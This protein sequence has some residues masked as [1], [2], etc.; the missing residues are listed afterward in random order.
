M[1]KGVIVVCYIAGGD[2]SCVTVSDLDYD[3]KTE[4]ACYQD[5]V[6]GL[7]GIIAGA[8]ARSF[9]VQEDSI[10]NTCVKNKEDL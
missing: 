2:L 8:K 10:I 7:G 3:H 6:A 9:V 1:F 5:N 4:V